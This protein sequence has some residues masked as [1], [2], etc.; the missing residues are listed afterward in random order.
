MKNNTHR[1]GRG[2]NQ[3]VSKE[4]FWR[5]AMRRFAGSGQSVRRF[6]KAGGLSE[7]SFYFWRRAL[8]ERDARSAKTARASVP[9]FVPVR[10]ADPLVAP[11]EIVL[12][13][14]RHVHLHGSVDRQVLTDVLAVLEARP[15]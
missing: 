13:G 12:G 5:E 1:D 11:I 9:A 7:P 4:Q 3:G 6:C 14:G 8:A 15:C 10:I 2:P